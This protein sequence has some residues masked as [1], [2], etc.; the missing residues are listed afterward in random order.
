MA[1]SHWEQKGVSIQ[2]LYMFHLSSENSRNNLDHNYHY[3][4]QFISLGKEVYLK[5]GDWD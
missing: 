5:L 4:V 3:S 1:K 2:I